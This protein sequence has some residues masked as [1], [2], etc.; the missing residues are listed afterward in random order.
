[1]DTLHGA[2]FDWD[3]VIIDSSHAHEQA[4]EQLAAELGRPLQPGFFRST[5]GMRNDRIIPGYS[6]WAG[7][8]DTARIRELG[9]RKEAL[10]RE[11]IRRDGILPLPGV[12]TLL[13]ALH[14]A[15]IPC[16][17]GSSTDRANIDLIMEITGLAPWFAAITAAEDV[18]R[19][20]PDPQVFVKAAEKIARDPR[21]CVVFEDA[22]VGIE[23]ALA[24][25]ARAIAVCTTHP[26]DSFAS[27][28]AHRIV[29]TLEEIDV[30]G[31][32]N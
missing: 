19:G 22:H 28:G 26:A 11:I 8:G 29:R 13:T 31:L 1:M 18:Q 24:A 21:N 16:S 20:K 2:L 10:Y 23:A 15:G 5:F 17:V 32:W 12:V 6:G 4:W 27:S 25:G 3:G 30:P 9:L 7:P 14:R